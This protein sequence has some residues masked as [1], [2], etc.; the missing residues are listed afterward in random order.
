M[1]LQKVMASPK[2]YVCVTDGGVI[3]VGKVTD[4]LRGMVPCA[5]TLRPLAI[6]LRRSSSLPLPS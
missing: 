5:Q 1:P 2:S 4:V 6:G 3:A